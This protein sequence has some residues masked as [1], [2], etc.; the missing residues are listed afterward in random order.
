MP[1]INSLRVS[2]NDFY[3]TKKTNWSTVPVGRPPCWQ[4]WVRAL[5][6]STSSTTAM[7]SVSGSFSNFS[8]QRS[9]PT[10]EIEERNYSNEWSTKHL[11]RG[12]MPQLSYPSECTRKLSEVHVP[13][14]LCYKGTPIKIFRKYFGYFNARSAKADGRPW[15]ERILFALAQ[16][17]HI[18]LERVLK[19]AG[20]WFT[21]KR[22]YCRKCSRPFSTR[23]SYNYILQKF[24]RQKCTSY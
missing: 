23:V 18:D 11:G 5:R 13:F 19:M 17:W 4:H 15:P 3:A 6:E 21:R 10:Y 2:E 16:Q 9:K 20:V 22:R 7:F 1:A 8:A 12:K 24:H 14:H